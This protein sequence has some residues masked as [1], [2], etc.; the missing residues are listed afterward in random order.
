MTTAEP[1][2]ATS[3]SPVRS[4]R[5]ARLLAA[6]LLLLGLPSCFTSQLWDMGQFGPD[7]LLDSQPIERTLQAEIVGEVAPRIRVASA[8]S[9]GSLGLLPRRGAHEIPALLRRTDLFHVEQAKLSGTVRTYEDRL[10]HSEVQLDLTGRIR[11]EAWRRFVAM[12]DLPAAVQSH[13]SVLGTPPTRHLPIALRACAQRL[14]AMDTRTLLPETGSQARVATFAF[15]D[16]AGNVVPRDG[17]DT[18]PGGT[19]HYDWY[20]KQIKGYTLYAVLNGAAGQHVVRIDP[21]AFWLISEL[22][23]QEDLIVHESHW[24]VTQGYQLSG[25]A[26]G[27]PLPL[28]THLQ[29]E[30]YAPHQPSWG[31]R[32]L[33]VALTPVAVAADLTVTPILFLG[34]WLFFDSSQLC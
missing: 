6:A 16:A 1:V 17:S 2:P 28:A 24:N 12:D 21:D 30:T 32:T 13:L 15:T 27:P 3:T 11:A 4:R 5:S 9:T 25:S 22:R 10:Q 20:A 31:T 23:Q 18:P 8:G 19:F 33:Q 14:L 29:V 26:D 7:V 34:F